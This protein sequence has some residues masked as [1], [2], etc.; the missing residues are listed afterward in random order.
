MAQ[1]TV[2]AKLEAQDNLSGTVKNVKKEIKSIGDAAKSVDAANIRKMEQEFDKTIN[3]GKSVRS[4]LSAIRKSIDEM[5]YKNMDGTPIFKKMVEKAKELQGAIDKT[6]ESLGETKGGFDSLQSALS[7]ISGVD[8]GGIKTQSDSIMSSFSG[9]TDK[10]G[11]S[12]EQLAKFGGYAAGVAAVAV[13]AYKCVD[14]F[15]DYNN[16]LQEAT[17]LTKQFTGLSGTE[18]QGVRNKAQAIADTFGGD[19][20]STMQAANNLTKQFGVSWD[21][22]LQMI[23]DGYTTGA[24]ASGDMIDSIKE[25][26]TYFAQAGVSADQFMAI[27]QNG[28]TQGIFS[29]K[30]LDAIKEGDLR[31][32]EMGTSTKS[33]LEGIGIDADKMS[34]KLK[35]GSMTT[36]EAMQEIGN[37]MQTVSADSTEMQAAISDIFGGPGEDA[38]REY[39]TMLGQL[40]TSLAAAKAANAEYVSGMDRQVEA[41]TN[42]KNATSALFDYTDD[43]FQNMKATLMES[44]Y[45]PLTSIMNTFADSTTIQEFADLIGEIGSLGAEV[46]GDLFEAIGDV[47]DVVMNLVDASG[48]CENSLSALGVVVKALKGIWEAIKLVWDAVIILIQ[49]LINWFN[50]CKKTLSEQVQKIPLMETAKKA[51]ETVIGWVKKLIEW[52]NKLTKAVADY[53]KE[54][55]AAGGSTGDSGGTTTQTTTDSGSGGKKKTTTTTTTSTNTK[56]DDDKKNK[57]TKTTTTKTTTSTKENPMEG[58]LQAYENELSDIQKKLKNGFIPNSSEVQSQI[59]KL[60]AAIQ[61]KKIELGIEVDPEVAANTKKAEELAKAVQ[62]AQAQEGKLANYTE[63]TSSY[64]AAIGK[65]KDLMSSIQ[66]EMNYNDQLISKLQELKKTYDDLGNTEGVDRVTEKMEKLNERQTELGNQAKS[67]TEQNNAW[68]A[69]QKKLESFGQSA[70]AVGNVF[71]SMGSAL[72][73]CGDESA[74]AMMQ[75]V[76]TTASGVAQIIPHIM[77]LIGAKQGEAMASGTASAAS[78]PYPANIVAIASII[79]TVVATFASIMSAVGAF[80]NGGIVGGGSHVGDHNLARVNSGEMIL[81]GTQQKRLFNILDGKGAFGSNEPTTSTVAWKIKGSDL[82]GTLRN[83]S[84]TAAKTGK[85]TGIK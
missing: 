58:S 37:K 45:E 26:S 32:R 33:A 81:N 65:K 61:Q 75:I 63:N 2:T 6:K 48:S 24:N 16:K 73:A 11:I 40:P 79:S 7:K 59:Q 39:L 57:K 19:F 17:N 1:A 76:S 44:V 50:Q 52:W 54:V 20:N 21:D 3:S 9:L 72:S 80:A 28:A 36:M 13:A 42:L 47:I 22:A 29:D 10:I 49:S 64:D 84:K 43:G 31:I 35:N 8:I 71:S 66:E 77:A 69:Q 23:Q 4:Q 55:Q 53:K 60:K 67:I 14:A 83:Y 18:M 30:A 85:I 82:Y 46:F 27:M 56:K 25:Y 68:E 38:G 41:T 51:I 5:N 62:N 12:G 70:D 78:L 15:I 74:A 34:E